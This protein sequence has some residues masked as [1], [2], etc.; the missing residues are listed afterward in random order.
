M[1]IS[2]QPNLMPDTNFREKIRCGEVYRNL[3]G[4]EM[5]QKFYY[6][7]L[8]CTMDFESS[9]EFEEHV[10]VHYLQDDDGNQN[11]NSSGSN[12]GENVIDI[13][14][15]DEDNAYLYAVEVTS[16]VEDNVSENDLPLPLMQMLSEQSNESNEQPSNL[17]AA[18]S[19]EGEVNVP[20]P[21]EGLRNQALHQYSEPEKCC[22]QCPAYFSTK[23]ELTF[24][25][26]IHTMPNTVRCPYCFEVF[27]NTGKLNEHI[28]ARRKKVRKIS[29][30]NEETQNNAQN[31]KKAK[32]QSKG[33]S[34][35]GTS[36]TTT[37]NNKTTS[38][39]SDN[40][41]S[42]VENNH[43]LKEN[44]VDGKNLTIEPVDKRKE[45]ENIDS[46]LPAKSCSTFIDKSQVNKNKN[47]KNL[48]IKSLNEQ[49]SKHATDT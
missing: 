27:A 49:P 9:P 28:R 38:V 42:T 44:N 36:A 2:N 5:F 20:F 22:T 1:S 21:C 29:K 12:A 37:S 39:N 6:R 26:H 34:V 17:E 16:L 25:Q 33:V 31:H 7:C 10:I 11:V 24:H 32:S 18:S 45:T 14:S 19:D 3:N 23:S 13:S 40:K 4:N 41:L 43:R 35:T 48:L 8:E 47:E 15:D 30:N 46:N